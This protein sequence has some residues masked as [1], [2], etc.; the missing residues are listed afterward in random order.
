MVSYQTWTSVAFE[1]AEEKGAQIKGS[2]SVATDL[3]S[4]AADIWNERK[5]ELSTATRS[6]ARQIALQEISVQ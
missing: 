5:D 6:E 2:G 1:V 4:V 3:I